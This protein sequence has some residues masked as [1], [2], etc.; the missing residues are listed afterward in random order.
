MKKRIQMLIKQY[1][2]DLEDYHTIFRFYDETYNE[3]MCDYYSSKI[4][5]IE[6]FIKQLEEILNECNIKKN[7]K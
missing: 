3:K 1:K 4:T 2:Q 5:M 6:K 7:N